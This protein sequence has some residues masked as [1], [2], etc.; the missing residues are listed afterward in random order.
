MVVQ[1][2]TEKENQ[3]GVSGEVIASGVSLEDYLQ[4]YAGKHYEWVEGLVIKTAPGMLK[5]NSLLYCYR[6]LFIWRHL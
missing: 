4:D 5:H 2:S 6:A 3:L 1:E